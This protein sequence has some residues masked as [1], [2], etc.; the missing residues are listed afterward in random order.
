MMSKRR[1]ILEFKNGGRAILTASGWRVIPRDDIL[2]ELLNRE[3]SLAETQRRRETLVPDLMATTAMRAAGALNAVI[4]A[5]DP[6]P[7]LAA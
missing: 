3:Y 5:Y 1:A 2:S 7:A 4:I 6:V